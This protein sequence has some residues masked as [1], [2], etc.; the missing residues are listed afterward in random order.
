M[1]RVGPVSSKNS[2][3][4]SLY[5][6]KSFI[7]V[8]ND[9]IS[10]TS[11]SEA[12][13]VASVLPMFSIT[14]RVCARISRVTVPSSSTDAPVI[15]LSGLRAL[16][17]ETNT[18]SPTTLRWGNRPRGVTSSSD[19]AW[20]FIEFGNG[21]GAGLSVLADMQANTGRQIRKTREVFRPS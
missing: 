4:T 2:P 14:A 12:P 6:P 15:E 8:R 18:R 7:V 10:T 9:V 20:E 13:T 19:I 21:P 16:V 5:P 3:Q 1:V 11:S 17:P